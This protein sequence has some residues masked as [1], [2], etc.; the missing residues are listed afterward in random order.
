M[1]TSLMRSLD[2]VYLGDLLR[3]GLCGHR[4]DL[5][6]LR[7]R[8]DPLWQ[9]SAPAACRRGTRASGTNAAQCGEALVAEGVPAWVQYIVDPLY[10][11]PVFADRQTYG[12]SG[13]PFSVYPAQNYARGLCP[14]AELALS[15]VIAIHWNENYSTQHVLQIASAIKK[16]A[17]YFAPQALN[18]CR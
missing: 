18:S 3:D 8:A 5:A 13:Y 6:A 17:A 16:V 2:N 10:M 11:S 4:E 12:T 15:S 14:N 9:R 1:A 7:T